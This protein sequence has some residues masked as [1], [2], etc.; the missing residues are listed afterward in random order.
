[1]EAEGKKKEYN[2]EKL[3]EEIT[4]EKFSSERHTLTDSRSSVNP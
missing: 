4:G 2:A 1:M 3:F